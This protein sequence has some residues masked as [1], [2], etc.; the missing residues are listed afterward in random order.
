MAT[1]LAWGDLPRRWGIVSQSAAG[2]LGPAGEP[3]Q[4]HAVSPAASTEHQR[5]V[6]GRR[7]VVGLGNPHRRDDGVGPVVVAHLRAVG[8]PHLQA[9]ATGDGL[10]IVDVCRHAAVVIIVDAVASGAPPGT[11]ICYDAL[12]QTLPR[13]WFHCSTHTLG[14]VEAIELARALQQLPRRLLV[15]GVEGRDFAPGM[16]L[17]AAVASAVPEVVARIV[18]E[19]AR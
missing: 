19:L 6:S 11:I 5:P 4:G 8:L 13:P 17:S 18:R 3:R 7:V 9:I 16:G 1:V 10:A 2:H 15:Y 12:R 14:V